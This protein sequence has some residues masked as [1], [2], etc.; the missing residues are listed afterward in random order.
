MSSPA[1]N[2]MD[3]YGK[4]VQQSGNGVS[5]M[6]ATDFTN[7]P[8]RRVEW[9]W[10]GMLAKQK[11][12]VLAG[13]SGIGKTMIL[14][15]I[16]AVVSR[17]G[18]FPGEKEPCTK[19]R[20]LFLTGEDGEDDTIK[21]RLMASG[22][23]M[24]NVTL[25][26]EMIGEEYFTVQKHIGEL[27]SLIDN[28]GDVSLLIIDPI[29]AFCGSAFDSNSNT[30]VRGI[31]GRL[32]VL[33][34]RTGIGI[35]C[36]T[37]LT[38]DK[39]K[40]LGQ[41]VIGSGAWYQ[42]PRIVLGVIE[43]DEYGCV[44]GKEKTNISNRMGCYPYELVSTYI[45]MEDGGLEEAYYANWSDYRLNDTTLRELEGVISTTG[46]PSY[47]E[48]KGAAATVISEVLA[49]GEWHSR[50]EVI[51][52]ARNQGISESTVKK[53]MPDLDVEWDTTKTMPA[54]GVWRLRN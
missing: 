13:E 40:P 6:T 17:G 22:A 37:H 27:E 11:V 5:R 28:R 4:N 51:D 54:T 29:T 38:K 46:T 35:L 25:L 3:D 31:V 43:H 14:C 26:N 15:Q 19:G 24:S 23:D 41:R 18:I 8:A 44:L 16:S 12:H 1:Y 42:A 9:I 2:L 50:T 33:A 47:G 7:I 10:P 20:V 52:E 32:T 53:T 45:E 30:H 49:D 21:P 48:K 39:T 36:L 34:K